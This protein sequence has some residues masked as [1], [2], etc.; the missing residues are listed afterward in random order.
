MI[1]IIILLAILTLLFVSLQRTY[2]NL[3]AKELKKRSRNG[4]QLASA[5]YRAAS[6]GASL[7]VVLWTLI[8]VSGGLFFVITS[9]ATESWFAVILCSALLW[10]G[11]IW[12]PAQEASSASVWIASRL[13]P[14]FDKALQYMSPFISKIISFVRRHRP[15]SIHT[16]LYDK[17]DL[18]DLF[19]RQKVQSDSR[20]DTS[21]LE[22]VEHALQFGDKKV[23]D[24]LTPL[25]VV[26]TV[27]PETSV[28][29]ILMDDIHKS[30]F[31]RLPVMSDNQVV[32]VLYAK[33]LVKH[34]NS[35]TVSKLMSKT[36]CYI[37][38]DQPLTEALQA[39]LKTRQQLFVVVNGFEEIVGI[40]TMEDVLEA[41]IGKQIVD[42]FDQYEDLRAVATKLADKEHRKHVNEEQALADVQDS[43]EVIE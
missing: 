42:E 40:V 22:I 36:V 24:I 5:L 7:R 25:R 27:S 39:I 29:P 2:G 19:E 18:L 34:K 16:G 43:K 38:E 1:F 15:I 33:D 6:Y 32:G 30:G 28:G 26:K 17:S 4:D 8:V 21:T 12:M 31:S 9:H 37:H 41:I 11:F 14:V 23:A 3:P 13:A 35:S 10:V 20:V